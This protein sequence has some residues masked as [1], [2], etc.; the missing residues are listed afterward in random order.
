MLCILF[1]PDF[2]S[3]IESIKNKAEQTKRWSSISIVVLQKYKI[4]YILNILWPYLISST[5]LQ[6]TK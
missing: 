2:Y 1:L 3:R 6:V 5:V 4:I